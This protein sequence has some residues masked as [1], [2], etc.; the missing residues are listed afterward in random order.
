MLFLCG[1]CCFFGFFV[2]FAFYKLLLTA[3]SFACERFREQALLVDPTDPGSQHYVGEVVA[4]ELAHQW[5]GNL[6]TMKWWN[7]VWLNEGFA[8]YMSQLG[9]SH[10]EPQWQSEDMFVLD[11]MQAVMQKDALPSSHPVSRQVYR[12][13]DIDNI[14]DA[15]SYKKGWDYYVWVRV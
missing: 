12:V 15:I 14:F 10:V 8:T 13:A 6:V 2:Y 5:F 7:D 9:L 4:H 11:N 1:C 3:D